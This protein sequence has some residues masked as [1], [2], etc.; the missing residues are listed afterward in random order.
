MASIHLKTES[1][2]RAARRCSRGAPR[3]CRTASGRPPMSSWN[4]PKARSCTTSTAIPSS[5]SSAASAR[6]PWATVHRPVVRGDARRGAEAGA[7]VFAR[8]H[9]RIVRAAVRAAERGHARRVRQ[10]DAACQQRRRSGGE[11]GESRARV[12][13]AAWRD[14]LRGRI[15]RPH[16]AH[17]QPDQQVQ[18]VQERHGPVRVR[19]SSGCRCPTSTARK[20][21]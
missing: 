19:R 4:A 14:L 16:A 3:R 17:A 20:R 15:S 5:T 7:H 9:L 21:A 2:G 11:R 18:P 10:E 13:A 1:P 8:R 12:Y 6:S